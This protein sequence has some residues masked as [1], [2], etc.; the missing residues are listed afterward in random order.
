M[1]DDYNLSWSDTLNLDLS[2]SAI[3]DLTGD[4]DLSGIYTN[5]DDTDYSFA[6]DK[7][8]K[9][10]DIG[11]SPFIL[12]SEGG[13][14]TADNDGTDKSSAPFRYP[15]TKI[16]EHD[17]YLKL[18]I[19][20]F[21]PPGLERLEGTLRL[22]TSDE[23]PK[24]DVLYTIML[25]IPQGIEDNKG[26]NWSD[27][28]MGAIAALTASAVKKGMQTQGSIASM[29]GATFGEIQSQL[30]QLSQTDRATVGNMLTGTTASLV[31]SALTGS[32]AGNVF[33]RETGLTINKNQQL[34]FDG[35]TARSFSFNWDIVPRSK[36]EAEQV[37][38]IIRLLK[39]AMSPQR[40][41]RKTVQG[42]FLKSPDVFYLTYMHGKDMHPFLNAFKPCA[43][44]GMA[45]NYT[46][47][48]TY[49]TYSDGTPVHL[50]LSL[51]FSEL[52]AVYREDY[53][54]P[55]SGDGV[56]Y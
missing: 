23:L 16:E 46:G 18:E 7:D 22:K 45:V 6:F 25:P 30:N 3:S 34:L 28:N 12:N 33:G 37:K 55:N 27:G 48:G 2:D 13:K 14:E 43:L 31:A 32:E 35:I 15:Y 26:A 39:Q 53:V 20:E 51:N 10:I 50:N 29:A 42:L 40:G 4:L 21:T 1:A 56:G 38:V 9:G 17:D 49:A 44:T 36:K 41:G 24:K 19:V 54:G 11:S 8:F 5:D 47:S 52:T